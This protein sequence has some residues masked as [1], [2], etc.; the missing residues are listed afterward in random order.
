MKFAVFA[1]SAAALAL[2]ACG[3]NETTATNDMAMND[4][5]MSND[6]AMNDMGM[7]NDTAMNG[8]MPAVPTNGQD[9]AMMAGASDAIVAYALPDG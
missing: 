4:M 8:A 9:Y 6:M 2:A 7:A 1:A 5:A 3:D